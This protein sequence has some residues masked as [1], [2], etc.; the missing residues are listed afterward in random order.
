[1]QE[2]VHIEGKIH[3]K[4][5]IK[6]KEVNNRAKKEYLIET[7]FNIK[8]FYIIIFFYFLYLIEINL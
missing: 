7:Y 4:G 3:L 1:M 8:K 2:E 5:K 6:L